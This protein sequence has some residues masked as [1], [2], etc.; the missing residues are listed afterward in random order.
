MGSKT[1]KSFTVLLAFIMSF[2]VTGCFDK[3][4]IDDLVNPIA[5]GFDKGSNHSVRMTLQIAIPTKVAGG[6]EGGGGG[7]GEESVSYTTVEAPSIYSGLNMINSYVSKQLNMSQIKVLVFSEE[8]AREGIEKYIN[9]L[10]RGREFRPHSY[11]IVARGT[12]NAAERYLRAVEPELESNPAKYYEMLLS[13]YTYTGFTA[14]TS[15]ANFYKNM[16]SESTQPLAVLADISKF[17]KSD[18]INMDNSSYQEK[19]REFPLEGDFKAGDMPKVGTIKSEVMGLAVFNGSKMVG[20]LDGEETQL[21]LM[22]EGNFGYSYV[23]IPDPEAEDYVVL[24]NIKQNRKPKRKV[25]IVDEKPHIK[26]NIYLE[27]DILSI[28][29]GVNYE[30]LEKVKILEDAAEKFFEKGFLRML[31]KT[32][33]EFKSDIAGFGKEMKGKFLTWDEWTNFNWIE[34]YPDSEFEVDVDLKIRRPGL[35]LRTY[36]AAGTEVGEE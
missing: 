10:M 3:R 33:K 6:G 2:S 22:L 13:A 9:A 25:E 5:I 21:Q 30:S 24:L 23:T 31:K 20:E 15:L 18:D 36:P 17:E 27:A 16:V 26:V 19:G 32:A 11:V 35:M 12:G 28:Q 8:L 1:K 7:G 14:N 4:E 29:S 34:K